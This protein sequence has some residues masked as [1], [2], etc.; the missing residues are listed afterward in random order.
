MDTSY[1]DPHV[2]QADM[3]GTSVIPR[4]NIIISQLSIEK[5]LRRLRDV[6]VPCYA[7]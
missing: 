1:D 4:H 6:I 2:G 3:F 7:V 5:T